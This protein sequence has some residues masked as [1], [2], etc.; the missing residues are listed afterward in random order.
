MKLLLAFS[1][2]VALT[3]LGFVLLDGS[4]TGPLPEQSDRAVSASPS[5]PGPVR[6]LSPVSPAS[7]ATDVAA[8]IQTS[9]VASN[10]L[11][12]PDELTR[13]ATRS[14]LSWDVS[15]EGLSDWSDD[16]LRTVLERAQAIAARSQQVQEAE[17]VA[18]VLGEELLRRERV[19]SWDS[20]PPPGQPISV[21]SG[22]RRIVGERKRSS[23][24][25]AASA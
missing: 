11:D 24:A 8:A 17:R 19:A 22:V 18:A 12:F 7:L 9:P 14:E 25:R 2:G 5:V 13:L 4:G 23:E 3:S 1:A 21:V 20:E 16:D 15:I 6:A 10:D